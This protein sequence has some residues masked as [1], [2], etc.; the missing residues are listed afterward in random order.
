MGM[1]LC[2]ERYSPKPM[3]CKAIAIFRRKTRQL[4]SVN[5][6]TDSDKSIFDLLKLIIFPKS[7]QKGE[8]KK[9]YLVLST[10][11]KQ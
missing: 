11:Y 9:G 3:L 4:F 8:E 2:N 10:K 1:Y 6:G 7:F 5:F